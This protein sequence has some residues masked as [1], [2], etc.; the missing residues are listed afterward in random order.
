MSL[1]TANYKF[2]HVG[3]PIA[4]DNVQ[5]DEIYFEALQLYATDPDKT[6][7]K[8]EYL[9]PA[10]GCTFF[11]ILL[12]NPHVSYQ[13]DDLEKA[14]EGEKVV[15]PP[16]SPMPGRTIAFIEVNGFIFEL[17]YDEPAGVCP[18]EA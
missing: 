4:T 9:R 1:K 17:A 16:F 8:I 10:P 6:E 2:N 12:A 13:V 5:P 7:Y 3:V 14:L 18:I 11:P 15:V